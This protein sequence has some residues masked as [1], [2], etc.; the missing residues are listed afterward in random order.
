MEPKYKIPP[1]L[2]GSLQPEATLYVEPEDY[3]AALA[4][5]IDSL[6]KR[7]ANLEGEDIDSIETVSVVEESSKGEVQNVI[8]MQLPL[9]TRPINPILS[10][11]ELSTYWDVTPDTIKR[12]AERGNFK[13]VGR[14]QYDRKSVENFLGPIT[15]LVRTREAAKYYG[16]S[17]R[18]AVHLA[19]RGKLKAIDFGLR[20]RSNY[21]FDLSH[22]WSG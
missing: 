13:R 14:G 17:K 2:R 11:R 22:E 20:E 9:I 5:K 8:P 10:S 4:A 1:S 18:R 3:N 19:D 7:I 16:I 6:E 21:R 12:M 15:R